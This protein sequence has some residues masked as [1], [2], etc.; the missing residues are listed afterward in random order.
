MVRFQ[1]IELG[2]S[3]EHGVSITSWLQGRSRCTLVLG[4]IIRLTSIIGLYSVDINFGVIRANWVKVRTLWFDVM[5]QLSDGG[6]VFLDV[7]IITSCHLHVVVVCDARIMFSV[8]ATS[9]NQTHLL[10][11]VVLDFM[12]AKGVNGVELFE[13]V[14]QLMIYPS[15]PPGT[16]GEYGFSKCLKYWEVWWRTLVSPLNVA[17]SC[18]QTYNPS[19]VPRSLNR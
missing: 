8:R 19:I 4:N 1:K 5:T 14:Y 3:K 2:C 16:F 12:L 17:L 13:D 10:L 18:N 15:I 6:D 7:V 9:E 11:I